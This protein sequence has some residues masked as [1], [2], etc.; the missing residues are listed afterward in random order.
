[1]L[2]RKQ[3]RIF[4]GTQVLTKYTWVKVH[5]SGPEKRSSGPKIVTSILRCELE[6]LFVAV[7]A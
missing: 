1:M 7:E 6:F 3:M 2:S 5:Y 4:Q